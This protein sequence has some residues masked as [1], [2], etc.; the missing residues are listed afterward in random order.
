MRQVCDGQFELKAKEGQNEAHCTTRQSATDL[1]Q[2]EQLTP[3]WAETTCWAGQ[4]TVSNQPD[5]GGATDNS[6]PA[7]VIKRIL[8]SRPDTGETDKSE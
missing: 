6:I 5:T 7:G 3:S 2:A 8:A 1:T 4:L